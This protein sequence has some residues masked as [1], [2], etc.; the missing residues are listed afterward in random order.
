MTCA[1]ICRVPEEPRA[2]ALSPVKA[3]ILS[4]VV[5][6]GAG[7]IYNGQRGKGITL[8]TASVAACIALGAVVVRNVLRALPED[9]LTLDS[10]RLYAIVQEARSGLLV[11]LCTAVL[12][13]LWIVSVVDAY[14]V[15]ARGSAAPAS[16][17]SR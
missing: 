4:A 16:T 11:A 1:I 15:A 2:K 14:L 12:T 7:Q 10:L 13:V 8:V 3:V 6:P 17:M 5:C 9:I